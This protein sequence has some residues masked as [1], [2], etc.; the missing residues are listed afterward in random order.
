MP[1]ESFVPSCS[2]CFPP[3]IDVCGNTPTTPFD[4]EVGCGSCSGKLACAGASGIIGESSC[5]GNRACY[6]FGYTFATQ[7]GTTIGEGSQPLPPFTRSLQELKEPILFHKNINGEIQPTRKV[8]GS[9]IGDLSCQG[10]SACEGASGSIGS[11][12]CIGFNAC[13]FV[14]FIPG[15]GGEGEVSKLFT[16]FTKQIQGDFQEGSI[17]FH[18]EQVIEGEKYLPKTTLPFTRSLQEVQPPS[19]GSES[20]LGNSACRQNR[21][22]IGDKSC[23]KDDAC[24]FNTV[25]IGNDSW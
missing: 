7:E 8:E 13:S 11:S 6:Q 14:P 21:G 12:S 22:N 20:C 9:S 10:D 19:I 15:D 5:F 4:A 1:S 25:R 16:S 2:K 23:T 17:L 3:G 24:S 18:N